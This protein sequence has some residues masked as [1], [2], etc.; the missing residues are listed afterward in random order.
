MHDLETNSDLQIGENYR[1]SDAVARMKP[2]EKSY[3]TIEKFGVDSK[4]SC[5]PEAQRVNSDN[6]KPKNGVRTAKTT[7]KDTNSGEIRPKRKILHE[8]ENFEEYNKFANLRT[9][10]ELWMQYFSKSCSGF[11]ENRKTTLYQ[12]DYHFLRELCKWNIA[13]GESIVTSFEKGN[14][15]EK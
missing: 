4:K 3:E 11:L 2:E 1:H 8:E 14:Y 13:R 15:F 5:P 7:K 6:P 10:I 12:E 9:F